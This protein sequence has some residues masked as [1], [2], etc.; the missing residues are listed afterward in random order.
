MGD[1]SG[2]GLV[3]CVAGWVDAWVDLAVGRKAARLG[4][5]ALESDGLILV[6]SRSGRPSVVSLLPVECGQDAS[7]SVGRVKGVEHE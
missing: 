7:S 6:E 2:V 5:R 1:Q 3:V 4:L